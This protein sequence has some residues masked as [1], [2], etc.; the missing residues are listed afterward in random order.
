MTKDVYLK[1][2]DIINQK[3]P[4]KGSPERESA[5]KYL[6]DKYKAE[7]TAPKISAPTVAPPA[8][9][10]QERGA[11]TSDPRL[12]GWLGSP[13]QQIQ[14]NQKEL[15]DREAFNNMSTTEQVANQVGKIANVGMGLGTLATAA[16]VI[17][18]GGLGMMLGSHIHIVLA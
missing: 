12:T 8:Q 17:A 5:L 15:A 18:G 3:F 11:V 6:N 4:V 9:V 16:P 13:E 1:N 14:R 7:E 2:I 10:E